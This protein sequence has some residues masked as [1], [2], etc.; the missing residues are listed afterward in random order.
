MLEK[1]I[2]IAVKVHRGQ[3]DKGG[4]PYFTS[5]EKY[6]NFENDVMEV[7]IKFKIYMK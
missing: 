6:D 3:V 4:N 5:S 7:L 1:A 2:L